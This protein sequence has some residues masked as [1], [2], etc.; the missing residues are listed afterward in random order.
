[1]EYR[2]WGSPLPHPPCPA[3]P[4]PSFHFL[5]GASVA[6]EPAGLLPCCPGA[7]HGVWHPMQGQSGLSLQ[8]TARSRG[9]LLVA[10]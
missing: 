2:V 5:L 7:G 10:T 3:P 1:M 4:H 8:I 6:Q 9:A